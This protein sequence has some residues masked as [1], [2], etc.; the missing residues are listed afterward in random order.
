MASLT[1]D[2]TWMIPE[3]I[4]ELLPDEA[5]PLETLRRNILDHYRCCGYGLVHP[6]MIEYVES[7]LSGTGRD[8]D[9]QTFKLVDQLNGRALG[10]RADMTPQVA[11]IDAH[12]LKNERPTRLCYL[13]TVLRT[14]MEG[15]EDSRSP[16][17]LGAEIYGHQGVESDSEIVGLMLE[18]L[19]IAG[20]DTIVLDL[21][22]VGIFRHLAAQAGLEVPYTQQLFDILQRKSRP[23]MDDFL[24][25]L[26]C[27][28]QH[29]QNLTH[30]IDLNGDQ[31][32]LDTALQ[33]FAGAGAEVTAAVEY[34]KSLTVQLG[35]RFRSIC[36]H[37]DL[38]ELRGFNYHNGIVFAAY[39]SS[40]GQV[41]ELARG[42]RY[43]NIGQA[44]GRARPATG[45]ST[46]LKTLA[47]LAIAERRGSSTDRNT[48][49]TESI[50]ASINAQQKAWSTIC[51][52]RKQGR[53]VV[54]EL[55]SQ[56]E[57]AGAMKCTHQLQKI[58]ND[59]RVLSVK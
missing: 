15:F 17:Q 34:L 18:T 45:F 25:A 11:R 59:W 22:H 46:D 27:A 29:K 21:G 41:R 51:Q 33:L 38:A 14:R 6:P 5:W 3:G 43:D 24:M 35:E 20:L 52:L 19:H 2:T 55:G 39:W 16:L 56:Y 50:F 49:L 37:I 13:G 53:Q 30:L 12:C 44:F 10:V 23:E 4:E 48:T 1:S 28:D 40:H 47:R 54:C 9:L 36:L 7:L 26:D 8:F 57:D 32:V 42:G 58:D 31:T